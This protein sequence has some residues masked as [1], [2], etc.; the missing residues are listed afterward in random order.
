M[1]RRR[2]ALSLGIIVLATQLL[3]FGV[4]S[5]SADDPPS[6]RLFAAS[7]HIDIQRGKHGFTW[8]DPG[9]WVASVGGAFEL[10]VGRPDYDTPVGIVQTDA[11]TAA[12]LRTL[13]AELL[14]GWFGL[15]NFLHVNV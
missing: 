15:G 5:A 1:R 14:D 8:F 9:A 10:R 2:H 12:E 3:L 4:P 7:S 6:L 11:T 13:P